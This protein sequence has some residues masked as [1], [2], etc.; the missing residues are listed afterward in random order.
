MPTK[1]PVPPAKKVN[2]LMSF[3]KKAIHDQ[4]IAPME[5]LNKKIDSLDSGPQPNT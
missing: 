4:F 3:I 5:K 1:E 2:T